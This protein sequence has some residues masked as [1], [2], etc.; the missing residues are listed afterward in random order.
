M[1]MKKIIVIIIIFIL[2][3]I[4][5]NFIYSSDN[6]I[7]LSENEKKWLKNNKGITFT[8][9]TEDSDNLKYYLDKN[10]EYKGEIIDVATIIE[11]NLG[12][13]IKIVPFENITEFVGSISS[14]T[15]DIYYGP[16]K[17]DSRSK[18]LNFIEPT[19]YFSYKM[20][21]F[22]KNIRNIYDLK[23]VNIGFI[24][25]DFIY[26]E[27]NKKN[28]Q[29]FEGENLGDIYNNKVLFFPSRREL[30]RAL[31]DNDVDVIIEASITNQAIAL[32][33]N[34]FDLD[35]FEMPR[36]MISVNKQDVVLYAILQKLINSNQYSA[37]QIYDKN[38][39]E[40]NLFKFYS[41]LNE[42]EIKWIEENNH[43]YFNGP[44][45]LEPFIY[46]KGNKTRG[47]IYDYIMQME[48][49]LNINIERYTEQKNA[50][51]INPFNVYYKNNKEY[52]T[53]IPYFPF[54]ITIVGNKAEDNIMNL[55]EL[56]NNT[57]AMYENDPMIYY[58]SKYYPDIKIDTYESIR[59]AFK[60][61]NSGRSEYTLNSKYITEY[62][63]NNYR[64]S[65]LYNI[66]N[67]NDNFGYMISA[68]NEILNSI[69]NKY[70]IYNN[71]K[72]E[73]KNMDNNNNI[74]YRILLVIVAPLLIII[75]AILLLY[76]NLCIETKKRM[77][78]EE[79]EKIMS[80][81]FENI[82]LAIVESLE[83]AT[84]YSDNETGQH[85][86]RIASYCRFLATQLGY[87]QKEINE[88]ANYSQLHDIGKIGVSEA[89]L[90][91][92]GK[93]TDE[94]YEEIKEHVKI[95]FDMIKPLELGTIAE[96]IILYH[97]ERWD[98]YGYFG[99]EGNQIPLESLIVCLADSYDAMRMKRVYKEKMTHIETIE[100]IKNNSSLQF[101]PGVVSLFL[102][103]N[104]KFDE[105]FEENK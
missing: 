83:R 101:A 54:A 4:P 85:T 82:L 39:D 69:L 57:V 1:Y 18:Y 65:K 72:N 87:S 70:I 98:G 47:I 68:N 60:G 86:R 6:N 52:N 24:K 44:T 96:N 11:D 62:Y 49:D 19:A 42:K 21:T 13:R 2:V 94:E 37:K 22:N 32:L 16:L 51:I 66:G 10:G 88:I 80:N 84:A 58:L 74:N 55:H 23:D 31:I 5:L 12:I 59:K 33:G 48:S 27:I 25:N 17:N 45:E 50:I 28:T 64:F 34:V 67:L 30:E 29:Y 8:L 46:K 97:H 92:P 14:N 40:F 95:G 79:Q 53:C 76:R 104:M 91:K 90:K 35:E 75:A 56:E 78:V 3:F 38:K 102:K 43:I 71:L 93:L 99:L 7:N 105:I 20:V 103:Y 9:A 41:S 81:K 100:E 89:I 63:L 73:V 77:E 61:V 15:Y 36:D 26:K